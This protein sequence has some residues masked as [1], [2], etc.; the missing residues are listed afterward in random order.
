[1]RSKADPAVRGS[2]AATVLLG[3][4]LALLGAVVVP[5][6]TTPTAASASTLDGVI[7]RPEIMSRAQN[8]VN[9]RLTYDMT[10]AWASDADG[11]HTYRRD[12]SGFVSMTWHLSASLTTDQFL[13][14]ARAGNGMTVIARD[15]LRP[16][17][18]MV[19]D[20]DGG[21]SDGHM[22][23][24]SHWVNPANHGDGAYVYS[25]NS[26]GQTV[27]NPYAPNNV[28]KLG[29]NSA[30]EMAE[31][32]F[33]RYKKVDSER[34]SDFS[35]D[36]FSDVLGVNA[37]GDLMYYPNNGI[38]VAGSTARRLDT[39]WGANSQVMA[40]DFSGDGF[41]DLFAVNA[42]GN[43]IYYPNNGLAISQS[44]ARQLGTGF[45]SFSHVFASDFSGDEHADIL[46]VDA[47]GNLL[48]FPNNGL[49]ISSS[50]QLDTGWGSFIHAE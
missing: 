3:V 8:W 9:R 1:M 7:G 10:G 25:F 27:Q 29:K 14:R 48:Y 17:D 20:S 19:R 38:D 37:A 43:L 47:A 46:G 13:A 33:I 16:G 23:L 32:T 21:G 31:Y 45:G 18:A 6:V 11:A 4:F 35:G 39:G 36:G 12:C 22:E 44:T 34:V 41:A 5:L 30:G 28:G 2:R 50:Q 49:A 42:A 24:F 26:H 40:A 15:A